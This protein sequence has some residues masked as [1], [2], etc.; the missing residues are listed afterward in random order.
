MRVL[1][2]DEFNHNLDL[3]P[4]KVSLT[5]REEGPKWHLNKAELIEIWYR[6]FLYLVRLY[7][8]KILVPCKDIDIFWHSH[9]LD[10]QKYMTD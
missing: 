2:F 1:S 8:E 5:H 3:E 4:I 7:P 6:R 9:I 10:T